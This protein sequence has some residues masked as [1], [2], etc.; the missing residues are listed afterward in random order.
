MWLQSEVAL[1][2]KPSRTEQKGR[3]ERYE[4]QGRPAAP[5]GV[6]GENG[7]EFPERRNGGT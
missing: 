2:E 3:G 4:I 7:R 5:P 6:E 1:E